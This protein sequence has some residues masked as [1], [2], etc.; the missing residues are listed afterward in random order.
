[1]PRK[2]E[3]DEIIDDQNNTLCFDDFL[4]MK[5]K[6][7]EDKDLSLTLGLHEDATE[8]IIVSQIVSVLDSKNKTDKN[9]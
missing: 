8:R 6:I 2:E 7:K 3:M 4:K 5:K 9:P 1:M